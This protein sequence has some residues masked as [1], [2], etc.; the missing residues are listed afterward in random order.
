DQQDQQQ[1]SVTGRRGDHAFFLQAVHGVMGRG[2]PRMDIL[3]ISRCWQPSIIAITYSYCTFFSARTS[4]T[5]L[6]VVRW[7]A[8]SSFMI[9]SS[10]IRRPASAYWPWAFT[11]T[12][13]MSFFV[14]VRFAWPDTEGR[15]SVSPFSSSGVVM[16]KMIS[17]TNA[18]SSN[19][20]MLM[21][22]NVTSEL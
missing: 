18:R 20:V 15:S 11:S 6:G 16:T 1:Q 10:G 5:R 8:A 12:T 14:T 21:S 7:A 9:R 19:G 17:S 2:L 13:L 3:V 22:L 4:T